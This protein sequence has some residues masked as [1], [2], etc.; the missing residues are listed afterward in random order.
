MSILLTHAAGDIGSHNCLEFLIAGHN[1]VAL[2]NFS[3][4]KLQSLN[5]AEW[6]RKFSG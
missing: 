3:D 6:I 2:S 1:V 5:R 4:S